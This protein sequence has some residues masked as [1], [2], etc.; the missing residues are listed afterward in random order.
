[1]GKALYVLSKGFVVVGHPCLER[2]LLPR[3]LDKGENIL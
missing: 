3:G 1:V 2:K